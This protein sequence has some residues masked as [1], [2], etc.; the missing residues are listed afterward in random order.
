MGS[1]TF[2][3][4]GYFDYRITAPVDGMAAG[5]GDSTEVSASPEAQSVSQVISMGSSTFVT[6]VSFQYHCGTGG[7]GYFVHCV[8]ASYLVDTVLL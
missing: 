1:G 5:D 8:H 6:V 3:T 2:V 4:V 7:E